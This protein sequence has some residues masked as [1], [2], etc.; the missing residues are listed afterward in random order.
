MAKQTN[1]LDAHIQG[2]IARAVREAVELFRR[3]VLD[4]INRVVGTAS[5][6]PAGRG[7]ASGVTTRKA[8]GAGKRVWPTCSKSGCSNKFFG[9]SGDARLCYQH[10]V[11]AGGKHP[12][13]VKAPSK[14]AKS[15]RSAA[16][17]AK[18]AQKAAAK[19]GGGKAAAPSSGG[20]LLQ[21]VVDLIAKQPGLRAEQ[22]SKSLGAKPDP[23]KA[24]LSTLRE[25]GKVKVAG[26]ARGTTY[27]L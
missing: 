3:S 5:A 4:D 8:A 6:A 11:E 21:Q 10:Y 1:S 2:V 24:V 17:P 15:A 25:S 9:P 23:V 12:N 7:K 19:R 14:A 20:A 16:K 22:I 18:P 26:K 13:Q 27:S